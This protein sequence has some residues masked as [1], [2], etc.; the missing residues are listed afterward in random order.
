MFDFIETGRGIQ[1]L[2]QYAE[3]EIVES[4]FFDLPAEGYQQ[5]SEIEQEQKWYMINPEKLNKNYIEER[6]YLIVNEREKYILLRAVK[7]INSVSEKVDSSFLE[8]LLY[9]KHCIP[10][11]FSS[12]SR[13]TKNS[14]SRMIQL[15]PPHPS[16]DKN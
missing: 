16:G 4:D 6:A 2:Y 9:A 14:D 3:Q 13:K 12:T 1:I 7:F 5:L 10:D 11:C 8:K 15:Y